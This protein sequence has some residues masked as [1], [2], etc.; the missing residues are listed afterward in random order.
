MNPGPLPRVSGEEDLVNIT[1]VTRNRLA[2]TRLCLEALAA[3]T[4]HPH[5]ITVVDNASD[6]GTGE[7]LAGMLRDGLVDTLIRLP[8]NAGVAVAANLGWDAWDAPYYLKCDND[9]YVQ[10]EDWLAEMVA[11]AKGNPE[12]GAVCRR[13]S[14]YL[15]LVPRVLASGGT[16]DVSEDLTGGCALIPRRTHRLLGYWNE[17]YGLYGSEDTDY[18]IRCLLSGLV[19]AYLPDRPDRPGTPRAAMHLGDADSLFDRGYQEFKT[20]RRDVQWAASGLYR[21]N[22]GMYER[23]ERPLRVERKFLPERRGDGSYVF[24]P[25]P[26]YKPIIARQNILRRLAKAPG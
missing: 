17:D 7:Y 4:A 23:G 25:N 19:V 18:G 9:I 14:S 15:E 13:F 8:R 11:L 10:R 24:R 26:D 12:A 5:R 3:K 22:L 1:M 20:A 2:L 6:D 21:I 16:V